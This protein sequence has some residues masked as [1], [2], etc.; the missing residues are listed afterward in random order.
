[1]PTAL[2]S[3]D[4][5]QAVL[6]HAVGGAHT[7]VAQWGEF[8]LRPVVEHAIAAVTAQARE[9]S[10]L[11]QLDIDDAARLSG[12]EVL[13]L[14]LLV[15]LLAN[16]VAASPAG[17]E[18]RIEASPAG[19]GFLAV[20]ILDEGPGMPA[21]AKAAPFPLPNGKATTAKVPGLGLAICHRI[22]RWHGGTLAFHIRPG[23]G[24][25]AEARLRTA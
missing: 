18:V 16:A 5:T 10:I 7:R 22:A 15:N 8:R 20:R 6:R 3:F 13:I 12:D 11:L 23:G 4:Q 25:V 24:T 2:S 1:L 14:R 21:D 19:E 17:R 9:K